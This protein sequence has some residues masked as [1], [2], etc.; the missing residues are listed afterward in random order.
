MSRNAL[1][2]PEGTTDLSASTLGSSDNG[3]SLSVLTIVIVIAAILLFLILVSLFLCV[4]IIC[5]MMKS[6]DSGKLILELNSYVPIHSSAAITLSQKQ[7]SCSTSSYKLIPKTIRTFTHSIVTS[8]ICSDTDVYDTVKRYDN[9]RC[10][11]MI[12]AVC[13]FFLP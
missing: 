1:L 11:I 6:K 9:G 13:H 8:R 4:I 5:C 2:A 10:A 7:W 12:F 3:E